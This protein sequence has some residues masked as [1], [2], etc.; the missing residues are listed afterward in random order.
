MSAPSPSDPRLLLPEWLRDA[1]TPVAAAIVAKPAAP[2]PSPPAAI[3]SRSVP[4]AVIE[5]APATPAPPFSERL[6]LDTRLDPAQLVSAADLPKWLGGVERVEVAHGNAAP[7]ALVAP[8]AAL[9]IEE[10]EPYEG[11]DAPQTGIIDVEIDAWIVIAVA[12]GLLVL[13]F[14]AFRL[15]LS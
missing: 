4:A 12:V 9:I 1:D 14:A 10:P 11:V 3:E 5:S 6:A 8:S 7:V 13:L 15:Y 2:A